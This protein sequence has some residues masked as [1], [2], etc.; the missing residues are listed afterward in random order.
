MSLSSFARPALRPEQLLCFYPQ[1]CVEIQLQME[2][3]S[4]D[5]NKDIGGNG[6]PDRGFY[7]ID[8]SSVEGLDAKKS[9]SILLSTQKYGCRYRQ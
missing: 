9:R 3:F 2:S 5:G 8:G 6:D 1:N 4:D 7:H